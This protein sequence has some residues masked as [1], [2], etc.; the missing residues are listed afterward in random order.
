MLNLFIDL[1]TQKILDFFFKPSICTGFDHLTQA[2]IE[3]CPHYHHVLTNG[4]K[5]KRILLTHLPLLKEYTNSMERSSVTQRFSCLKERRQW[6]QLGSIPE[7]SFFVESLPELLLFNFK[8]CAPLAEKGHFIRLQRGHILPHSN[9][10]LFYVVPF[11]RQ[12]LQTRPQCGQTHIDFP[13]PHSLKA[14]QYPDGFISAT[15]PCED[16]LVSL[17]HSQS[18]FLDLS[19]FGFVCCVNL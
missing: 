14:G 13:L 7:G 8:G 17:D 9:G 2:T 1:E 19:L 6:R 4:L 10:Q 18:F 16:V 3:L 12:L 5:Q 11:L 15:M